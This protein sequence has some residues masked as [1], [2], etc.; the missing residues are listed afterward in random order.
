[1]AL[2]GC[3]SFQSVAPLH[4]ESPTGVQCTNISRLSSVQGNCWTTFLTVGSSGCHKR[5]NKGGGGSDLGGGCSKSSFATFLAQDEQTCQ[6]IA[7][8]PMNFLKGQTFPTQCKH[9][10]ATK[11]EGSETP[12]KV[13]NKRTTTLRRLPSFLSA[14]Q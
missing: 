8:S 1:M 2:G 4:K 13:R 11:T 9:I 6:S 7:E 14:H 3:Q 10:S 12:T 5:R